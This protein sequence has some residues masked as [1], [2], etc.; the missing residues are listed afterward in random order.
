MTVASAPLPPD[1]AEPRHQRPPA[2]VTDGDVVSWR[3]AVVAEVPGFRP[4]TLDLTRP[5]RATGPSPLIIWV[6]GGAWLF[7]SNKHESPQLAPGRIAERILDAGF[8]LARV[9][10]RFS[11]EARFPAQLHDVKAAVRWLRKYAAELGLDPSRFGVW[12]E[13]AGGH[14]ASLVALTGDDPDPVLAGRDGVRGVSDAVQ[15]A[16][17]WYGPANLATMRG[18]H[19]DPD[20]PESQLIGGPVPDLPTEAAVASPVTYVTPDAPPVLLV[21]GIDDRVVPASQ[22]EEL[23]DRLA[24]LSGPVSLRLVPGADHCFVGAD[25][26]PLVSEA[27]RH[28][29]ATL[30]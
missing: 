7:G 6:H 14:L 2:P 21:H 30:S 27:L 28:F 29:E 1:P 13:S 18:S 26:D 4:L 23:H 19:N 22:S 11:G 24:A 25:L 20:S 8:A 5:A 16:V 15:S 9:T 12:G 3:N 17:V 10:Y